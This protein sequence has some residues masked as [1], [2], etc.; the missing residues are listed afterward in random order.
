MFGSLEVDGAGQFVDGNGNYQPSGM[1]LPGDMI[2]YTTDILSGTY[3][4]VTRDGM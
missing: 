2:I 3:R 1:S 4:I